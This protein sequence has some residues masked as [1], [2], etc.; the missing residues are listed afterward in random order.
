MTRFGTFL[1]GLIF[2]SLLAAPASANTIATFALTAFFTDGATGSGTFSLDMTA[3]TIESVSITT[4]TG[5]F[6]Q[7]ASYP[8]FAVDTYQSASMTQLDFFTSATALPP[9][10]GQQLRLLLPFTSPADLLSLPT[11]EVY[12]SESVYFV[13]CGGLCADRALI[14]KLTTLSVVTSTT[15]IPAALPLLATALGGLGFM[16]WRHKRARERMQAMV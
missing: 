13:L 5:F 6:V 8:G 4:T 14:G 9:V 1:A 3:Q 2:G 15:P 16:G 10:A 7:G 12:G 11:F